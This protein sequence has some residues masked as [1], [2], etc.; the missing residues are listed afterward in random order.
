MVYRDDCI[1]PLKSIEYGLYGD[2]VIVYPESYSIYLIGNICKV[3]WFSCFVE[4]T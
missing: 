1:V 2:L 4:S 3:G